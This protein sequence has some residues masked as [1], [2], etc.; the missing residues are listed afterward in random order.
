MIEIC[1]E[2]EKN[3][4]GNEAHIFNQ[5]LQPILRFQIG[6]SR[7]KVSLRTSHA[8]AVMRFQQF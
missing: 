1:E 4:K 6:V 7:N 2:E 5:I 3:G 8:T